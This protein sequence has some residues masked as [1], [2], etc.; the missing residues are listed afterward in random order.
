MGAR[1]IHSPQ[2]IL[3]ADKLNRTSPI[4]WRHG[5]ALGNGDK[6]REWGCKQIRYRYSGTVFFEI[7]PTLHLRAGERIGSSGPIEWC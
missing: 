4:V 3:L 5:G 7:R 2:V 6:R 1:D